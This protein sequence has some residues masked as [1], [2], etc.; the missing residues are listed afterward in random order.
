MQNAID[1]NRHHEVARRDFFLVYTLENNVIVKGQTS[2]T[3]KF[4]WLPHNKFCLHENFV[5]LDTNSG[6]FTLKVRCVR[7]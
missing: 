7:N 1:Q 5:V 4:K 2:S 3:L 6:K